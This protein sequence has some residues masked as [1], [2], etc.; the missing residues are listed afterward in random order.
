MST[1]C[2]DDSVCRYCGYYTPRRRSPASSSMCASVSSQRLQISTAAA[3]AN[4][5]EVFESEVRGQRARREPEVLQYQRDRWSLPRGPR[6][7]GKDVIY[8]GASRCCHT[9]LAEWR[10]PWLECIY[11][12][13]ISDFSKPSSGLLWPGTC[14]LSLLREFTILAKPEIQPPIKTRLLWEQGPSL[15]THHF[16]KF[17]LGTLSV[18]FSSTGPACLHTH[19]LPLPT[20]TIG[21]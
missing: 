13:D 11:P 9:F 15:H 8:L 3:D 14:F 21:S 2:R 6:G 1:H 12:G 18:S 17:D 10:W 7:H 5:A 20:C 19:L 16:S 4:V